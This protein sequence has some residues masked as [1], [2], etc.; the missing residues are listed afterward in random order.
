MEGSFSEVVA[1]VIKYGFSAERAL[2]V[3]LKS[4]RGITDTSLPGAFTKD[5]VYFKGHRMILEFLAAGGDLKDLYYGKLN[6]NDLELVKKVKGLK[7]PLY[8]P[9]YLRKV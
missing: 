2:R 5:F 7:K 1:E 8:L 3:A 6:L 4:K 9:A